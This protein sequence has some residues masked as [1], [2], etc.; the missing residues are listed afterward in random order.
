MEI[1]FGNKGIDHF[2]NVNMGSCDG[3]RGSDIA[4]RLRMLE[5]N[6]IAYLLRPVS[7]ELDGYL[8]LKYNTGA[9]YMMERILVRMKPDGKFLKTIL[10]QLFECIR[11]LEQY[12]LVPEDLVLEPSYMFYN[13]A[14]KKLNLIY[15]PGYGRDVRQQ[16]KCLLEYIMR[17]FDHRDENGI[18]YLYEIYETVADDSF[19]LEELRKRSD[20]V[21][22]GS[23]KPPEAGNVATGYENAEPQAA[24]HEKTGI[25]TR[26]ILIVINTIAL[27]IMTIWYFINKDEW[28]VIAGLFLLVVLIIQFI[29]MICSV[30]E[31]DS[32]KAMQEYEML[33]EYETAASVKNC[34]SEATGTKTDTRIHRL[35]PLNNGAL[36]AI[37]IDEYK[38]KIVIGRGRKES[39]YRVPTTQISRAHACIYLRNDGIYL[40]DLNSTN[41]TYINSVRIPSMEA[42]LLSCGDIV[43]FANEEFFAS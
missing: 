1:F 30:K 27:G 29:L 33:R 37:A 15:I 24:E 23:I 31:D 26:E 6:D 18:R 7:S 32:D 13:Y 14:N 2:L 43:S 36:C 9:N 35:L 28:A 22:E 8:W 3:I 21:M 12:L 25:T 5:E 19:D 34:V 10:L 4:Y 40:E 16:L 11:A 17:I 38:D 39:D 20:T 42:K 41:G